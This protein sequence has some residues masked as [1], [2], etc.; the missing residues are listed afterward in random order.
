M[1]WVAYDRDERR[2]EEV[3]MC[4]TCGCK[5]PY[6]DHGDADNLVEDDLKKA[7]QTETIKRAGVK[8]SKQNMLELIEIQR[9]RGDLENPK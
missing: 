3:P 5:L 8:Q 4:Y 1:A 9:S 6:E 7:G 2:R